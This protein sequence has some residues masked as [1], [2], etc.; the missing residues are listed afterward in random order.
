VRHDVRAQ[1]LHLL[2]LVLAAAALDSTAGEQD[3]SERG[4]G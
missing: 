4:N 3:E 1:L 2:C